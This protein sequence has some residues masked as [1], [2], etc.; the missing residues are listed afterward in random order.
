[1]IF[2]QDEEV[3]TIPIISG[4]DGSMMPIELKKIALDASVDVGPAYF[5]RSPVNSCAYQR[6]IY[7]DFLCFMRQ[8]HLWRFFFILLASLNHFPQL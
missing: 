5:P 2:P 7:E 6:Q 1:M 8:E 3:P 4:E